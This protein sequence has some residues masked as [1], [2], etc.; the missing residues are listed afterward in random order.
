MTDVLMERQLELVSGEERKRIVLRIG[1]P[2][3]D[4][5][6]AGG[7][8]WRCPVEFTGLGKRPFPAVGVDAVQA[9]THALCAARVE[10]EALE[11]QMGG[12]FFWLDH[13]GHGLPRIELEIKP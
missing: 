1:L 4:V 8:D 6:T 2:V 12:H 3:Q 13:E 7:R 10:A 5:E 11:R 9:V